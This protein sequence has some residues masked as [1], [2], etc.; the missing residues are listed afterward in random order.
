VRRGACLS[1]SAHNGF[2][3]SV[4]S[5]GAGEG[6]DGVNDCLRHSST[7]NTYLMLFWGKAQ[8][9]PQKIQD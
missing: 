4:R 3:I 6:G 7:T 9:I 8:S 1:V 2:Q 5:A